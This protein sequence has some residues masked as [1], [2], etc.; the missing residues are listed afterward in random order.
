MIVRVFHS[1]SSY[2]GVVVLSANPCT[3][4][5]WPPPVVFLIVGS[6]EFSIMSWKPL[7]LRRFSPFWS[8]HLLYPCSITPARSRAV[9]SLSQA[10]ATKRGS[11]R[12]K[13]KG[14][15]FE[16]PPQWFDGIE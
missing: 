13:R 4:L 11:P 8:A 6:D 9:G 3:Q 16:R 2:F 7:A 14:R 12:A 5:V 10:S 15:P 1:R